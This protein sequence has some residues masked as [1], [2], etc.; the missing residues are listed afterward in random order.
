M[1]GDSA[2]SGSLAMTPSA[3]SSCSTTTRVGREQPP[4]DDQVEHGVRRRAGD[5][6]D[7]PLVGALVGQVL[8]LLGQLE[9]ALAL[10]LGPLGQRQGAHAVVILPFSSVGQRRA[11]RPSPSGR[12]RTAQRADR[13]DEPREGQ[14]PGV[15][16]DADPQQQRLVRGSVHDHP[17]DP[18]S[19]EPQDL[20]PALRAR[21]SRP[22][23]P[24]GRCGR[25][26][27]PSTPPAK[28]TTVSVTRV[29]GRAR[30]S[31]VR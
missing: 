23:P 8:Q 6:V 7:P 17:G 9:G 24:A 27:R 13:W 4:V 28:V 26:R 12:P 2:L 30:D 29:H 18:P 14:R 11:R 1:T 25:A 19:G 15:E 3:P 5:Q 20:R 21:S 31:S 16:H 10:R 22:G